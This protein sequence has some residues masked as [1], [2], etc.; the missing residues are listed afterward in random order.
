M[1]QK[2]TTTML[3]KIISLTNFKKKR[4]TSS[5]NIDMAAHYNMIIFVIIYLIQMITR[6][7]MM[8]PKSTKL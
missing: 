6:A 2:T 5:H 3:M 8:S 4:K 7:K 1:A